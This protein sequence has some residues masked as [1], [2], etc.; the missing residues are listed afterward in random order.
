MR[1]LKVGMRSRR[2]TGLC[3]CLLVVLVALGACE[4]GSDCCEP[5]IS[6][7]PQS[8][9]TRTSSTGSSGSVTVAELCPDVGIV[10]GS[11]QWT[12]GGGPEAGA[13]GPA[14]T[15]LGLIGSR[16]YGVAADGSRM[17]QMWETS[18]DWGTQIGKTRFRPGAVT[19]VSGSPDGTWVT[20]A[21]CLSRHGEGE[22]TGAAASGIRDYAAGPVRITAT[23][24]SPD[25]TFEH[26][27]H[28]FYE[29]HS[30][31]RRTGEKR[32]MAVGRAPAWAPDSRR[33]AFVSTYDYSQAIATARGGYR[34]WVMPAEGGQPREVAR[35]VQGSVAWTPDSQR[36]AFLVYPPSEEVGSELHLAADDGTGQV[37]LATN[38]LSPPA[39]SPDGRRLAYARYEGETMA[40]YSVGAAGAEARR[41]V[42]IRGWKDSPTREWIPSVAW[43]PDGAHLLYSC[44]RQVCVVTVDGRPVGRSPVGLNVGAWSPDGSRVAVAATGEPQSSARETVALA[45]MA[46]NGG[47][48]QPLVRWVGAEG[49]FV[50]TLWGGG[51]APTPAPVDDCVNGQVVPAPAENPGLVRD[52][53]T[54]REARDVL[55]TSRELNWGDPATPIGEWDGVLVLGSPPRVRAL[56]LSFR[57]LDGPVPSAFGRLDALETL[58]LSR[59]YVDGPLPGELGNLAALLRLDLSKTRIEGPIPPE[60][61]RLTR[62]THLLLGD[63]GA[64][65][66]L[67]GPLPR[68]LGHMTA[69]EVLDIAGR[70]VTG[71]IPPEL[72]QL[73]NLRVLD[74]SDN[75]LSGEIPVEL[76]EL[77]NLEGLFLGSNQLTGC[78]PAALREVPD[79]D[80]DSGLDLP[81]CASA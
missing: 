51:P 58:N 5:A 41:V 56:N 73:A 76:A 44:G 26:A 16:V 3:A 9:G 67:Q 42:T 10:S 22:A 61:G 47:D 34:L 14:S 7:L 39:W 49:T 6:F 2:A 54:L 35:S 15:V 72:G 74:F 25:L 57:S 23:T 36:L 81:L 30:W 20:Y 24:S 40:L 50:L 12:V 71:G 31:N 75:Q 70:Q 33:L 63:D 62:L 21:G 69:L 27:P 59:T 8:S 4:G 48:V 13:G 45:S 28:E 79:N 65:S 52:C 11:P 19:W 18:T 55:G 60:L 46:P 53:L 66:A 43:S 32:P 68:E 64:A 78:I 37:R 38:V 77:A 17:D 1:R 29:I 80:L